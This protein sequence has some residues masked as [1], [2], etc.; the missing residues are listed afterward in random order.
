MSTKIAC[1]IVTP[2]RCMI[3]VP[4]PAPATTLVA[5]RGTSGAAHTESGSPARPGRAGTI[6]KSTRSDEESSRPSY[7]APA[8]PQCAGIEQPEAIRDSTH[9]PA[10]PARFVGTSP[11]A[12]RSPPRRRWWAVRPVSR[13]RIDV[14]RPHGRAPGAARPKARPAGE[15]HHVHGAGHGCR[16][17]SAAHAGRRAASA[18]SPR[19]LAPHRCRLVAAEPDGM[20]ALGQASGS[21]ARWAGPRSQVIVHP[22]IGGAAPP[23]PERAAGL[24]GGPGA[25]DRCGKDTT[26]AWT[27][28]MPALNFDARFPRGDA[29]GIRRA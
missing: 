1:L 8:P 14:A 5:G 3:G 10:E 24:T 17:P 18:R 20:R 23:A 19:S 29:L 2:P 16:H 22:C 28:R 7:P 21:P 11:K 9:F 4:R 15:E 25:G 6:R 13:R 26:A 27:N 12:A